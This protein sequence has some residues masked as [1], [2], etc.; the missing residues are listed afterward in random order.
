M[1]TSLP[2][3][4]AVS[5]HDPNWWREKIKVFYF[6][7]K[8]VLRTVWEDRFHDL[9]EVHHH[10]CNFL[11]PNINHNRRKAVSMFRGSFKT[12]VLLGLAVY[13]MI[14]S[15]E[16]NKPDSII[17]NTA[18]RENAES[19]MEDFRF[20]VMNCDILKQTYA[21]WPKSEASFRKWT[22]WRVQFGH[23]SFQVASL[24]TTQV[25]RHARQVWND[26][27]VNDDN[28]Y[29]E[30]ERAKVLRKWKLQKSILTKS[31]KLKVGTELEFGTP[32]HSQDLMA[33]II[34]H[35]RGYEKF[36]IPY[37][38]VGLKG[39]EFLTFPE[40]FTW[41]DFEQI[42]EDQGASIFATQYELNV[43]DD[44]DRIA[45]E[46]MVRY[47]KYPPENYNRYLIVD[48]AGTENKRNDPSAF[49][50][51][52]V[53]QAGV[54]YIAYA[55]HH[56]LMPNAMQQFAEQLAR[57]YKVDEVYYEREKYSIS[58][59]DTVRHSGS[60]FIISFVEPKGRPKEK[61]IHRL[62]QYFETGRIF[63]SQ[64]M[65]DFEDQLLSYPDCQHDDLLDALAYTLDKA[66]APSKKYSRA[67]EEEEPK[68]EFESEMNRTFSR[69]REIRGEGNADQF[70]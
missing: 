17:Y 53:D 61:R 57:S 65:T 36:I 63:L 3:S 64:G 24:D 67:D 26:D 9:G 16:D 6:L 52:D 23:F 59:E 45:Y 14:R 12:T 10:L 48:P 44:A 47:Y 60:T 4:R 32:Y 42:R 5:G 54:L 39:E 20:I 31:S 27:L 1:I 25:S 37:K 13:S 43:I 34:K 49:V 46:G 55:Q 33:H 8:V 7:C 21:W 62:K 15:I 19:F 56:W 29:S 58:I 22:K 41:E 11:D 68:D 28:A 51:V 18:T 40:V 70:Y 2:S 66:D 69:M 50:V 38:L 30:T 35:V